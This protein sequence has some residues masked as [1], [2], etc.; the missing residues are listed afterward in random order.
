MVTRHHSIKGSLYH[1]RDKTRMSMKTESGSDASQ[2]QIHIAHISMCVNGYG[3]QLWILPYNWTTMRYLKKPALFCCFLFGAP[4]FYPGINP[5]RHFHSPAS[6]LLPS[7]SSPAQFSFDSN[8]VAVSSLP[9][10]K[11][12]TLMCPQGPMEAAVMQPP[13]HCSSALLWEPD[14]F[15]PSYSHSYQSTKSLLTVS[16]SGKA[17]TIALDFVIFTLRYL[18]M[19]GFF[20]W[21]RCQATWKKY[22][23]LDSVGDWSCELIYFMFVMLI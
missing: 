15:L 23:F 17:L 19:Q 7:L 6:Y 10:K 4:P 21:L 18:V 2:T 8:T 13:S 9:L 22:F 3:P 14:M 1:K 5:T 11:W 12:L 16:S 20:L